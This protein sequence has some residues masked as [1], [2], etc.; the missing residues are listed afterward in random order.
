MASPS[1]QYRP[2]ENARHWCE[3]VT[4]FSRLQKFSSEWQGWTSS[5]SQSNIFQS[6]AWAR[7]YWAAYGKIVS[8]HSFVVH[9]GNRVAGILPLVLRGETLEFL[10][11]PESDCNDLLCEEEEAPKVLEVALASLLQQRPGWRSGL[12]DRLPADSRI[13]RSVPA[14]PPSLRR[15]LQLVFKCPSPTILLEENRTQ[16]LNTLINKDQLKRYH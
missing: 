12:L 13:V 9:E 15:H 7:A 4:D 2:G 14:L 8:L 6:W 1:R 16:L 3:F 11:S 5:R 10:G